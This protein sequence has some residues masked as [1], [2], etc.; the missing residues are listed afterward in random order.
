[1][2]IVA[3]FA[4]LIVAMSAKSERIFFA[5]QG[6]KAPELEITEPTGNRIF[7]LAELKGKY[8][9]LSFWSTT[10][11]ESRIAIRTYDRI[12]NDNGQLRHVA[13]N[14]DDSERLFREILRRDGLKATAQFHMP[15]ATSTEE[16]NNTWHLQNGN[17]T[18]LIDPQ[19]MIIA[20][21][22]S[23]ETLTRIIA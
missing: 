13:V 8:V 3:L 21:D 6:H 12:S 22:P 11:A 9:L 1:M 14:T 5:S 15:N 2:K 18:Y 7:T 17:H 23:L 20:V 4:V 16:L 19:G 10:D